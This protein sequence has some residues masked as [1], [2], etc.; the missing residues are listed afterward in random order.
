MD[1]YLLKAVKD[2]AYAEFG[3]VMLSSQQQ[4]VIVQVKQYLAEKNWD[5]HTFV[6]TLRA[7][8]K[9]VTEKMVNLLTIQESY[10]FRDVSLFRLLRE[11]F[12]P[13]LIQQK[14]LSQDKSITIW[15][16]GCACGE[17][18][19]STA[20]LLSELIPD[21]DNWHLTL[22]GTDINAEALSKARQGLYSKIA[23]RS[24]D[25]KVCAKYFV[26]EGRKYQLIEP[27]RKMASFAYGNLLEKSHFLGSVD[28]IF[29]INVFIYFD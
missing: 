8:D 29:F 7:G 11:S 2:W 25:D 3:L 21:I 13:V 22:L 5:L 26:P 28:F 24:V 17:E 4:K 1:S 19:Y 20:I 16:A 18:L 12:L 6:S 27:I 10:F 9:Q 14:K 23:L 15:S